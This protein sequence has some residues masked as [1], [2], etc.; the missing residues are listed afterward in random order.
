MAE[1]DEVEVEAWDGSG[2][3]IVRM[4]NPEP[5]VTDHTLI[6]TAELAELRRRAE[7]A[8][9]AIARAEALH[10]PDDS[11]PHGPWCGT[12]TTRWPCRTWTALLS[13]GNPP[14]TITEEKPRD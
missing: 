9:A 6:P 14:V 10:S 2:R 3:H 11:N 1:P 8:E 7:Q 4:L 12:C 5:P 13:A